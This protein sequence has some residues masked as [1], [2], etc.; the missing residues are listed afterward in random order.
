M[1]Y[2]DDTEF[3]TRNLIDLAM[4]EEAALA[5]KV[6]LLTAA[7]Q[8]LKVHQW[9]FQTSD[10]NDDFSDAYVMAAF[11]RAARAGQERDAIGR[12]VARLQATIGAQQAAVQAICGS[13][14]QI[15]KQGISLVHGSLAAAPSGRLVGRSQLKNVVWQARNQAL[16]YEEGNFRPPV[17][18]LFGALEQSHGATFSL[19]AHP[20]RSLAKQVVH[21]LGWTTYEA[22]LADAR[23]LGL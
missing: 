18:A 20:Q 19:V 13:I 17:V 12:E 6:A 8:R 23:A 3:A 16:H 22:Y 15:A 5:E 21:L 2:T 1:S 9:D 4:R 10:L 11:A 7:E 14:L